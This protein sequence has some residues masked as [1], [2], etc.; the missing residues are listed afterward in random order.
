MQSLQGAFL[1]NTFRYPTTTT[2]DHVNQLDLEDNDHHSSI[3][4]RFDMTADPVP[5]DDQ[6]VLLPVI[7]NESFSFTEEDRNSLRRCSALKRKT[8]VADDLRPVT[9]SPLEYSYRRITEGQLLTGT[10]FWKQPSIPQSKEQGGLRKK[11]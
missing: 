9:C 3:D 8:V 11:R 6:F 2:V 10:S 4:F 1:L 7:M 5:Q